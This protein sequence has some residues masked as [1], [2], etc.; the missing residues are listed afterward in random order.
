[1][2]THTQRRRLP[3][4]PD[5]IFDLVADVE[6][7]P[8]F[9][10]WCSAVRVRERTR[11][12]EGRDVV[13]ADLSVRFKMFQETFKSRVISDPAR[14]RIDI[15]YLDGPFRYLENRWL[16]EENTDGTCT[17]DFWIDFE[18]RS[19]ALQL[20]ISAVF[21]EAVRR[22]VSAFDTRAHQLYGAPRGAP[23]L[24]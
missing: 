22:M 23:R 3:Y 8:E 12:D 6:R 17:V 7:Y 24:G 9:L 15:D 13:V 11:D 14:R 1:M 5:K 4:P 18:F 10:P 19:R 2:T 21:S 16:F 20:L